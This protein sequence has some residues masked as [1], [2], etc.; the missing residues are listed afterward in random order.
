M[1]FAIKYRT[2][3]NDPR[4]CWVVNSEWGP[5]GVPL[6]GNM[7]CPTPESLARQHCHPTLFEDMSAA[8]AFIEG[9]PGHPHYYETSDTYEI[10]PVVPN[11]VLVQKG[12]KES[13]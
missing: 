13:R 8:I 6:D 5:T 10:V 11:M 12:W 7:G 3:G 4:W 1:K 9:W 2:S